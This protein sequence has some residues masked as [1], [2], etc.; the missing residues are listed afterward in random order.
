M[1]KTDFAELKDKLLDESSNLLMASIIISELIDIIEQSDKDLDF[2]G[3]PEILASPHE[4]RERARKSRLETA[5]RL[6]KLMGVN[7]V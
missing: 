4:Q 1:T 3:A 5:T 2:C 6:Q 7:N